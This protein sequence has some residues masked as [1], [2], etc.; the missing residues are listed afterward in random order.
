MKTRRIWSWL[1]LMAMALPMM[2]ACGGDDSGSDGGGSGGGNNGGGGNGGGTPT[3]TV[4]I[5]GT[6]RAYYQSKDT[7]RGQVYDLVTFKSDNTGSIIEEVG[8]GSDNAVPF[9]WKMTGN[10]IQVYIDDEIITWTIQQI[11]D[12]NT[13]VV[14]DGKKEIRVYRDG[15]GGGSSGGGTTSGFVSKGGGSLSVAQLIGTWQIYHVDDYGVIN[16]Q[17]ENHS[18]DVY[19]G[20]Q[21]DMCRRYEFYADYTY[22]K[23]SYYNGSFSSPHG[24]YNYEVVNG[25]I[26][27]PSEG[28]T[29]A[30]K[31]CLVSANKTNANEIVITMHYDYNNPDTKGSEDREYLLRRVEDSGGSTTSGFVS[32]GGGSVSVAQLVGKMWQCYHVDACELVNGAPQSYAWDVYPQDSYAAGEPPCQRFEFYAD[33]TYKWYE[34]NA[35]SWGAHGPFSYQVVA[36]GISLTNEVGEPPLAE[37]CL[38]TTNKTNA[39]E[40]VITMHFTTNDRYIEYLVKRVEDSGNTDGGGTT[41]ADST[42]LYEEPYLK[43]GASLSTVKTDRANHGYKLRNE[44]DTSITYEPMYKEKYTSYIFDSN[45]SGLYISSVFFDAST[46]SL[47]A[48]CDY[49]SNT[50]GAVYD[51]SSSGAMWYNA[52]DGKS[53]IFVMSYDNGDVAVNYTEPWSSSPA[54]KGNKAKIK[55]Q[56][57]QMEALSAKMHRQRASLNGKTARQKDSFS[58]KMVR[59]VSRK[60]N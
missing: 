30:P 49:V 7:S 6:W 28:G 50:L 31:Y 52:K 53:L 1:L 48:L 58:A 45:T 23:F 56:A 60:H 5:I 11:I 46:M 42:M 33:N 18:L 16:G 40:I 51:F 19:P 34:Y 2:V 3:A 21:Y 57:R 35:G 39:D 13:V 32:K 59:L 9:V 10:I 54:F 55:A 44:F 12:S 14:H 26:S 17:A 36:G 22:K 47:S 37:S 20:D 27:L 41:P 38:V 15:T 43:W 25:S 29:P 8:Y 24:P 4:N